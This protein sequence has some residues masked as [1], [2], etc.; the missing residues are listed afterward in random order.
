MRALILFTALSTLIATACEPPTAEDLADIGPQ[1]QAGG[2]APTPDV[3][4][5]QQAITNAN[6]AKAKNL[7]YA[8]YAAVHGSQ[9]SA[10]CKSY[11]DGIDKDYKTLA[12]LQ[13]LCGSSDPGLQGCTFYSSQ[14]MYVLD[15]QSNNILVHGHEYLHVVLG[16]QQGDTDHNHTDDAWDWLIPLLPYYS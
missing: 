9:P 8:S 2:P 13:S 5:S 12:N 3:G 16:C 10:G 4:V 11:V 6:M 1:V 14:Q 15:T 7:A